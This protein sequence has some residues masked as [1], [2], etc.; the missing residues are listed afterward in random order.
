[1]NERPPKKSAGR[2]AARRKTEAAR[3]VGGAR[4]EKSAARARRETSDDAA[5]Y[6]YCIGP[7]A[8]LE[9]MFEDESLPSAI[10]DGSGLDL[11]EAEEL[12]AVVSIVPLADYG[13]EALPQR[14]S[15]AVWTAERAMRHERAVEFFARRA[16]VAPLRFG[17]IYLTRE[18]VA[19]T[20]V[21]RRAHLQTLLK[22]LRGREEWGVNLYADRSKLRE[23]I[24][25]ASPRLRELSERAAKSAPGESYLL[26]K[27][28][29]SLRAE[30][31]REEMR[32]AAR[33]TEETLAAASV[34]SARLRATKDE[35]TEH[36][37][38]VAKLAFLVERERFKKFRDAAERLAEKHY[39]LGFRLEMTGPW[40]AYNF[41]NGKD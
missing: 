31:T 9:P 20:L 13:E 38:L 18:R 5:V 7:G 11:I 6:V 15:D 10:E 1:M 8:E 33:E 3:E 21:E 41:S 19:K 35:A 37:D 34:S 27:K 36:G 30:E 22:R 2:K 25:S 28:I 39:A 23:M 32:R 40:P 4:V 24:V 14:L 29:E 16:T 12:A 17:V 26:R